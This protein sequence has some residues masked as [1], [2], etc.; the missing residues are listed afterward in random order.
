VATAFA[1]II[2]AGTATATNCAPAAPSSPPAGFGTFAYPTT[3]AS[4]NLPGPPNTPVDIAAGALQHYVFGITPTAP[5][6]QTSLAMQFVCDNAEP[7]L[8]TP[9]VN[10]LF[11]VASSSPVPDTIAL[12]ATS[13]SDGI[14]RMP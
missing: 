7:P 9:G 10:N 1:A 11:I 6:P 13:T 8:Q 4:N 5:I 2:N 14:V 12:M 3:D